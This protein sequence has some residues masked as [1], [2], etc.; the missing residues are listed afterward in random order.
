MTKAKTDTTTPEPQT[1]KTKP[2]EKVSGIAGQAE[3]PGA[4]PSGDPDHKKGEPRPILGM[5]EG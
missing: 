3:D 5:I 2:G 1:Q 4:D